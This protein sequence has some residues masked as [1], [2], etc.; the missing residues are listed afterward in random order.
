MKAIPTK[1]IIAAIMSV[2]F[3]SVGAMA[4]QAGDI[5]RKP[6]TATVVSNPTATVPPTAASA[7]ESSEREAKVHDRAARQ[8]VILE[9]R[10]KNRRCYAE[11]E[12]PS[13]KTR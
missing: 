12:M 3:L 10:N 5:R 7:S 8:V 1:S 4:Q 13:R 11:N 9:Q 6:V 2:A